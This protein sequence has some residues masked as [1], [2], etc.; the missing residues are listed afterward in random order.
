MKL[1]KLLIPVAMLAVLMVA[2]N[3]DDTVSSENPDSGSDIKLVINEYLA[4]NDACCFAELDYPDWFEIYNYGD[5]PVDIGG[6]YVSDSKADYKA[7]QI[8]TG[9][10]DETTIQPGGFL[11]VFCDGTPENGTLH[12]SFKLSSG[13]EDITLTE[14]NGLAVIDELTFGP[15]DTDI[16]EGRNPDGSNNWQKYTTPTP[17]ASN[18]GEAPTFPPT[19]S[20]IAVTPETI[21]PG[22]NVTVTATVTDDDGDLQS[23]KI[24]YGNDLAAGTEADMTASGDDYSADLGSFDDGSVIYFFITA[25]DAEE[26]TT[27][28]DTLS[29]QVGFVPPVLYINEF[30]ASNDACCFPEFDFPDWIEIYNPSS[31]P[32]NIGGYYITDGLDEL[33]AW[34]IPDTQPDSTTI[35]ANGFLVLFADKSPESGVLHVNLKLSGGGEQIGLTAPNGTTIIDSLTY[36]EQTTD[37]SEGRNPDGSDNWTNFESPTPGESN[38]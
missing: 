30:M 21:N 2:C 1:L 14:S 33:T 32:V 31:T 36:G 15:Q 22:D 19:I 7:F 38:N 23:V 17:G 27:V 3:L 4:S 8:P 18:S 24:T 26:Q 34:Q 9:H 16:S 35:P 6:M 13:G 10:S 5:V 20:N 11:V 25:A 37:V 29:F 12:T 28:S